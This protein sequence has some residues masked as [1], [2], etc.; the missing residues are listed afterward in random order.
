ME[1]ALA[2]GIDPFQEAS[3]C[4]QCMWSLS[5]TPRGKHS[6][7]P[8][9][10]SV[11]TSRTNTHTP[12]TDPIRPISPTSKRLDLRST[13]FSREEFPVFTTTVTILRAPPGGTASGKHCSAIAI[14]GSVLIGFCCLLLLTGE[15]KRPLSGTCSGLTNFTCDP[16]VEVVASF[17]SVFYTPNWGICIIETNGTS[18]HCELVG[19]STSSSAEC[20]AEGRR[21]LN[22]TGGPC[23]VEHGVCR[24][25]SA[26]L[27]PGQSRWN[28]ADTVAIVVPSVFF[29]GACCGVV[30]STLPRGRH[31]SE[32]LLTDL[33]HQ[34][35][36]QLGWL[37]GPVP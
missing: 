28:V 2:P 15:E 11:F 8:D 21:L 22:V 6:H 32:S 23:S 14:A 4:F 25:W 37:L 36:T 20:E 35:P 17:W 3:P 19:S 31:F 10:V 9:K 7:I 27:Q 33:P 1:V 5:A 26:A 12:S 34:R 13:R 16:R 18:E 30:L 29:L 24:L